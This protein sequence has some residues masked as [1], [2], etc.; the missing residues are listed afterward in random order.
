[1]ES[2]E[3]PR[4]DLLFGQLRI[5]R[6]RALRKTTMEPDKGPL[7]R[8]VFYQGS[9]GQ[10]SKVYVLLASTMSA[11]EGLYMRTAV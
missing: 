4:V 5:P 2:A 9:F 8:T 10:F 11:A 6:T 1:M 7:K 3:H